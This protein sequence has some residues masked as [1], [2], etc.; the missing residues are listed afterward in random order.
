MTGSQYE[1]IVSREVLMPALTGT[2]VILS[3]ILAYTFHSMGSTALT[4]FTS[5]LGIICLMATGTLIPAFLG[6]VRNSGDT[7]G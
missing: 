3:V 6:H 5:L 2:G 7:D 1:H 4:A